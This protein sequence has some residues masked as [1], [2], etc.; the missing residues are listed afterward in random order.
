LAVLVLFCFIGSFKNVVTAAIEIPLS[1]LMAFILMRLTG[2]NLNLISL[3]GLALSAGN[4]VDSSVVLLENIFLHFEGKKAA[5]S[6]HDKALLLLDAVNEVKLPIIAS[7]IASLV[8]FLPLIF[9]KGLTNS[10]LGDL[11]KAVIFSHGLSAV[12]ALILV[13]T[14]RL[15]LL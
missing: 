7:T 6:Y 11:A 8:V 4:N 10:L 1:L 3:G 14:I 2:M 5:M 13:P 15:Q 12:V 9:T